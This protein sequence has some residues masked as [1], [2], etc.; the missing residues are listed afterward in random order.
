MRKIFALFCVLVEDI[1]CPLVVF[2][3]LEGVIFSDGPGFGLAGVAFEKAL[4]SFKWFI[5]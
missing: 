5:S 3:W 4:Q 1:H 2:P